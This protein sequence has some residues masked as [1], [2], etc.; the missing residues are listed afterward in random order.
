[1]IEVV[2]VGTYVNKENK[3]YRVQCWRCNAIFRFDHQDSMYDPLE[4]G[5]YIRCPQCWA[6]T[7]KDKWIRNKKKNPPNKKE[8]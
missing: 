8:A 1:M 7:E 3:E 4:Y 6:M 5:E 2:Q